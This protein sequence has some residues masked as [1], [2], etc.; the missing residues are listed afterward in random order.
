MK[1]APGCAFGGYGGAAYQYPG[2][3]TSCRR[4]VVELC[5]DAA[6][7]VAACEE[8]YVSTPWLYR[9]AQAKGP[10]VVYRRGWVINN[11]RCEVSPALE[12]CQTG[13]MVGKV[14]IW[15]DRFTWIAAFGS[16]DSV[17]R[18][19]KSM[20]RAWQGGYLTGGGR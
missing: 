19:R 14:H 9:W 7:W 12:A 18:D 10:R 13:W 6:G 1:T 17:W 20:I 11:M 16:Q 8:H 4:P 15:W 5:R 3:D 2:S